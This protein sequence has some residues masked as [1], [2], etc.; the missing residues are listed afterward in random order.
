V[1]ISA[2]APRG[3]LAQ[4]LGSELTVRS[5]LVVKSKRTES[6]E[7]GRRLRHEDPPQGR[8]HFDLRAGIEWVRGIDPNEIVPGSVADAPRHL[9]KAGDKVHHSKGRWAVTEYG[10]EFLTRPMT[11]W[12]LRRQWREER[13]GRATTSQPEPPRDDYS[14]KIPAY[15]LLAKAVHRDSGLE[16]YVHPLAVAVEEWVDVEMFEAFEDCF[17][18]AIPLHCRAPFV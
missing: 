15:A 6:T 4:G 1:N 14:F 5:K 2:L 11:R 16:F 13:S 18:A 10:L 7:M 12:E 17:Y 8:E 3:P 9:L